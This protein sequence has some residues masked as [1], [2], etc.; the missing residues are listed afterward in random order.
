MAF[1]SLLLTLIMVLEKVTPAGSRGDKSMPS[2]CDSRARRLIGTAEHPLLSDL[3]L[4][5]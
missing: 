5:A 1:S 3:L 2:A 4:F